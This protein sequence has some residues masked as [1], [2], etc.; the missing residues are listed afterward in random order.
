[1]PVAAR[2]MPEDTSSRPEN[3]DLLTDLRQKIA[4]LERDGRVAAGVVGFGLAEIDDFLPYGG[5][6]G[7]AVHE[8]FGGA[9]AVFAILLATRL[10]GQV[11]WCI[12][13]TQR[14]DPYGPGLSALGLEPA[15]LTL[16][17]C[18]NLKE[19][20]WVMEEGLRSTAPVIVIAEPKADI[21]LVE[22]RR[23]QLAAEAGGTLGLILRENDRS[24]RLAPS[25]LASRWQVDPLPG[26]G[27]DVVLRRCRG[28][29][30]SDN[31][32][33]VRRDDATGNLSLVAEVGNRPVEAAE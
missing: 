16:A 15:R 32:W 26:G 17:R 23:L 8:F 22:S 30:V 31:E 2:S 12:E 13:D 11:L 20:L 9:A 6:C 33:K 18:R 10:E 19:M 7:G 14:D 4:S 21:G 29:T 1:M 28:T 25:A 3:R 24:G 27:W 5:L